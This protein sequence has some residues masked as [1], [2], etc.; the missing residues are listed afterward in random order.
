MLLQI[1]YMQKTAVETT[2]IEDKLYSLQTNLRMRW[3][4]LLLWYRATTA[5]HGGGKSSLHHWSDPSSGRQTRHGPGQGAQLPHGYVPA[6]QS[7]SLLKHVV[8]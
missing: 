6:P 4:L 1:T 8:L 5:H 7:L 2:V 3:Q